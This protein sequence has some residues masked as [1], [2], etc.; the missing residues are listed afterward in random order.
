MTGST[1]KENSTTEILYEEKTKTVINL[2]CDVFVQEFED[3][4][5]M[6]LYHEKVSSMINDYYEKQLHFSK[7][8]FYCFVE[9][10]IV[11]NKFSDSY[12]ASIHISCGVMQQDDKILDEEEYYN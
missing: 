7:D 2:M 3:I 8:E 1:K 11:T 5:E 10:P 9:M 6:D 12:I 4:K